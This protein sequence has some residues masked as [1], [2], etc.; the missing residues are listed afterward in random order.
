[1]ASVA[2]KRRNK[3]KMITL[4]GGKKVPQKGDV[5]ISGT[6]RAGRPI[7][8]DANKM[9]LAVRARKLEAMG[10]SK[11]HAKAWATSDLAGCFIG[12]S[13]IVHVH[14]D[15]DRSGLWGAVCQMRRVYASYYR[16]IGIPSRYAKCLSILAPSENISTNADA[17]PYDDRTD[18]EKIR[19]ATRAYMALQGKLGALP[20]SHRAQIIRCVLDDDEHVH[21]PTVIKGLEGVA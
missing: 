10:A 6:G 3:K 15:R 20:A 8:K 11:R 21:M 1:M 9:P 17:V 7:E 4:A 16:A 19:G 14:P 12:R 18:E 13:L 5:G 2:Q